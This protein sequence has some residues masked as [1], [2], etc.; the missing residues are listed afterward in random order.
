[1]RPPTATSGIPEVDAALG[2]LFWGD[3]VVWEADDNTALEPFFAAVVDSRARY[4]FAAYVT[5]S[6]APE[7]IRKAF[8]GLDVID[9]RAGGPLAQPGALIEAVRRACLPHHHDLLLFD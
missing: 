1:M 6:R 7:E 9:A 3:N 2:G 4:R 8:P 5:L